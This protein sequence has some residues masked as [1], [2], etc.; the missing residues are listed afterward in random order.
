MSNSDQP[1]AQWRKSS[2][3]SGNGACVEVAPTTTAT[4]AVRDS[5]DPGG[6]QLG[7]TPA[8]WSAFTSHLKAG[9]TAH[10]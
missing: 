4:V 3:S 10:R 1:R 5:K 7:F 2:R 6:P 8:Q 9:R